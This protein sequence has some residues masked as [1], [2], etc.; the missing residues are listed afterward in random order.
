ME[1]YAGEIFVKAS[2]ANV[3]AGEIFVKCEIFGSPMKMEVR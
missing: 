3:Y 2:F 1:V